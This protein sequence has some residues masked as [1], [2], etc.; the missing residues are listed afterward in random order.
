MWLQ[1]QSCEC[2]SGILPWSRLVSSGWFPGSPLGGISSERPGSPLAS[3][4]RRAW[5]PDPAE[6][7]SGCAVPSRPGRLQLAL[8]AV[9]RGVAAAA[10]VAGW[11]DLCLRCVP[12]GLPVGDQQQPVQQVVVSTSD[13]EAAGSPLPD[14]QAR[15]ETERN[16]FEAF[17]PPNACPSSFA[18]READLSRQDTNWEHSDIY[19][20]LSRFRRIH[21][22]WIKLCR[23]KNISL[24]FWNSIYSDRV[25][26]FYLQPWK[27]LERLPGSGN[28]FGPDL[29]LLVLQTINFS[30]SGFFPSFQRSEWPFLF[31]F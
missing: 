30:P 6:L 12:F 25:A 22:N 20:F 11:V 7:P 17:F 4:G 14:L 19:F 21:V 16:I 9:L 3:L 31:F 23:W 1:R 26:F 24:F 13:K 8:S 18:G 10:A 5:P 15:A 27:S 2:W 28:P 29:K